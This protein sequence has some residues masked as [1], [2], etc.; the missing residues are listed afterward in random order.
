MKTRN[1]LFGGII[2]AIMIGFGSWRLYNHFVVGLE[3]ETWRLLI[4]VAAIAYGIFVAYNV[5]T[6]KNEK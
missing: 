4:A 3:L 1:P 6:Q 2:A 5:L